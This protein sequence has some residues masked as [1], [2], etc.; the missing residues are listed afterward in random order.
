MTTGQPSAIL[1][2][3]RSTFVVTRAGTKGDAHHRRAWRLLARDPRLLD[4]Y[5]AMKA[6]PD[7]YEERKAAFF[8]RVVSLLD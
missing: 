5:R 6:E 4:E 2:R 8:E 7:R 1:A 3:R